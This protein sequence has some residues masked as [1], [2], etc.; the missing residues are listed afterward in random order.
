[1]THL[2]GLACSTFRKIS[3]ARFWYSD[4][5][6]V[7]RN[8]AVDCP[9]ASLKAKSVSMSL[10]WKAVAAMTP[11]VDFPVPRA[12]SRTIE[13]SEMKDLCK[14]VDAALYVAS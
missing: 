1:M 9:V 5:P 10:L 2:V 12:P 7:F 6:W 4:E 11:K 13:A 8:T 14:L 3:M